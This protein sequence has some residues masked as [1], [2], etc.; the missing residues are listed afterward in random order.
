MISIFAVLLF[1]GIYKLYFLKG[2]CSVEHS[3]K[4]I[5]RNLISGIVYQTV[6]IAL[7]FL[8]PRLYL[9]NFGSEVNG[10]LS[11]IKQIFTYMCLLEAGV[12]LAS[13]QALYKPVAENDYGRIGEI[14]SATNK[15]YFRTGVIYSVIVLAVAV[16]Y[17]FVIPTG[18][19]SGVVFA[20]VILNAIPALFSYFIQAKYRILMEV[21]G[22]KYVITNSET[23]L[24]LT[25]SICKILV[26]LL[27]DSLIL[28]QLSYC[29][30]AVIQLGYLYMYAR[31]KYSRLDLSVKPDFK[32][33][34]Q[35][36]SVLVHQI[37]GM[38]FNNTDIIL[39]S[40]LCSFKEVS[41]YAVYNIFFSQVQSFMTNIISG[42]SFALGQMF[43]TDRKKFD[44]Y[45]NAYE[46]LYIMA[47]FII[48]TLMGVF[49]LPLIQIYTKGINDANYTNVPLVFLFVLMNLLA[50]G[51]LPS[52]HVLEYAGKF[53]ETRSHAVT[54]MI[55]NITASVAAILKWGICGA[56]AGTIAALVYRGTVM[57]YYADKK[58]LGRSVFKTYRLW[59][60][61]GA[62]FALVMTVFFVD[63]FSGISFGQLIIQ[64][65]IHSI[66]ITGLYI[67][68]NF[69]FGRSS[70]R[71]LAK[72][73]KRRKL[74]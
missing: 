31:K 20:L 37:S 17:S 12:G 36:D 8:L 21:D 41:V 45:Y 4:K 18:I 48:Y 69:I 44:V 11:T 24:Q 56:I 64:G 22:R 58:V 52:N 35:K 67:G 42:F 5:K 26:L 71:T 68:V 38:V 28:I 39:L 72:M 70:F 51:K 10:V 9:E 74:K 7:S 32:A 23:A 27:T 25:S 29:I 30:L 3:G 46:S 66:W 54:E 49:L 14:L 53:R 47:S 13:S 61:N 65:I 16:V 60:V 33:I 2:E 6:L 19:D 55:I 50:N 15:Y 57:I 62:V 40:L 1:A 43:H 73:C 34:E 63:K 59:I